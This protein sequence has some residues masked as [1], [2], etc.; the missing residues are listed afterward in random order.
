MKELNDLPKEILKEINSDF[1]PK[2]LFGCRITNVSNRTIRDG[3]DVEFSK[4]LTV[5]R[6]LTEKE[7][8]ENEI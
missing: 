3:F 2:F 8:K 1:Y 7:R 6:I 5:S 4:V